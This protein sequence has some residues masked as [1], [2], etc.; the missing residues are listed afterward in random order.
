MFV[1]KT[2]RDTLVEFRPFYILKSKE[3]KLKHSIFNYFCL[4]SIL[5]C[6]SQIRLILNPSDQFLF[7]VLF[8]YVYCL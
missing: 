1:K 5:Y 3:T 4:Q 7:S 8:E 2:Y 6:F